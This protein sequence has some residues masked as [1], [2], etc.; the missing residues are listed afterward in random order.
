MKRPKLQP[1][2]YRHSKTHPYYL[3]LQSSGQG[4]KFAAP[5]PAQRRRRQIQAPSPE[6]LYGKTGY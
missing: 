6:Q 3:D 2:E 1:H 5:N 4:R